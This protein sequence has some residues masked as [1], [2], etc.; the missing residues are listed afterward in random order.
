MINKH[1][2]IQEIEMLENSI[3]I[4]STELETMKNTTEES[5]R[6]RAVRHGDGYQY[7]IRRKGSETN[8]EYI[9]ASEINRAI[10]LAQKEYDERLIDLLQESK[11]VL[12]K[13]ESAGLIDPFEATLEQMSSGKRKLVKPHHL[14]DDSYIM[15]WRGQE[16]EGLPF[17]E[18]SP[19]Y[20][21]R[22]GLRVRSK[23]EVLIADILDEMS[24]PF[25]YEKPLRFLK[26]TV[27]PDFTLL[28][29]RER[30]EVYWEHF[31]MM[32]DREYRE[33]AFLKMREYE[34]NGFYQYDSVIWTFE[35]G[36]N[37]LNTKWIRNMIKALYRSLGY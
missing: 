12:E 22:C 24:V 37:P 5:V 14:S 4:V 3:K 20:Y 25:L 32:D 36:K 33:D 26:K 16:Y 34:A 15:N 8:G 30:K 29:I 21:T 23:S 11:K 7:F 9:R 18:D 19:E 6:L 27:H 2:L 35:S 1:E 10:T 28:N 31:G 13:Y 17:K